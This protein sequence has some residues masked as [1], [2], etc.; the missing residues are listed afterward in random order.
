MINPSKRF[1]MLL[2]YPNNYIQHESFVCTQLNSFK[3]SKWL[4]SCIWP[5]DGT[6]TSTTTP[7]LCGPG[8]NANKG[9][10]HIPQ[11]SRTAALPS[12]AIS[13]TL[14][15]EVLPLCRDAVDVFYSSSQL[16]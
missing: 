9:V 5:I 4:N 14:V 11:S 6:L 1:Q 15:G 12:D 7:G 13:T 10:L 2:C 16:G 3:Y 8:S